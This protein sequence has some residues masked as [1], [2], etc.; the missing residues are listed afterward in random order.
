MTPETQTALKVIVERAVRPVRATLSRKKKMREEL[1]AHVTEVFNDEF[2]T[3]DDEALAVAK[4]RE[5][6]GDP[7]EI[8]RQL[9]ESV[10]RWKRG[11]TWFDDLMKPRP[12]D[13][14]VAAA[15]R[16]ARNMTL[17]MVGTMTFAMVLAVGWTDFTAKMVLLS[18]LVPYAVTSALLSF[19]YV[20]LAIKLRRDWFAATGPRSRLRLA[21]Y[22]VASLLPVLL[23][24]FVFAFFVGNT[25]EVPPHLESIITMLPLVPAALYFATRQY[26]QECEYASEWRSLQLD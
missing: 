20:L 21:F 19:S 15:L 11:Y 24:P 13:R 5:R 14:P 2:A 25:L 26:H 16:A 10:P 22:L 18:F 4:A 17:V 12:D 3:S 6:F 8:S 9:Q 23:V 7:Q 1:L